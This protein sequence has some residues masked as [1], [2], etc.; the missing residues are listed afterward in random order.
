MLPTTA[1]DWFFLLVAVAF[2]GLFVWA[3]IGRV[4]LHR[5]IKR[6]EK[7]T[8]DERGRMLEGQRGFEV[9]IKPPTSEQ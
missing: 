3:V 8:P 7:M 1:Y 4:L 5:D 2:L 6:R 9:K